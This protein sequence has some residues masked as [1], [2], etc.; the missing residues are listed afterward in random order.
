VQAQTSATSDMTI[1]LRDDTAG[2]IL[3]YFGY[4]VSQAANSNYRPVLLRRRLT[5]SAGARVYSVR[6]FLSGAGTGTVLGGAG[7]SATTALPAYLR[8]V[9][10]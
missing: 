2:T 9:K 7:G 1:Q 6:A 4:L 10:V 8:I 3:G 5:P